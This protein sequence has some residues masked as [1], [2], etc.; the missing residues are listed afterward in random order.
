MWAGERNFLRAGAGWWWAVT[1]PG[2]PSLS[3][4]LLRK[5]LPGVVVG[6]GPAA[7]PGSLG[8]RGE[9]GAARPQAVR[10]GLGSSGS[11]AEGAAARGV[12]RRFL[13]GARPLSPGCG[14]CPAQV[15][16][17]SRPAVSALGWPRCAEAAGR[18]RR[19]C[20]RPGEAG[21]L[22]SAGAGHPLSV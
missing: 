18:G 22:R 19:G 11:V 12:S 15:R 2:P 4:R 7:A 10:L 13:A 5:R 9:A 16:R 6:R 17:C 8:S 1:G 20:V 3:R 21:L 14:P